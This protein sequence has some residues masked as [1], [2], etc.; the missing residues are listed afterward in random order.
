VSFKEV[1][2]LQGFVAGTLVH[3]DKGLVPIEQLKVGDIV[4]SKHESGQG[5]QAYKR[6]VKT[7]KSAEK[8]K[9]VH[10]KFYDKHNHGDM[11]LFCTEDHSFWVDEMGGWTPLNNLPRFEEVVGLTLRDIHHQGITVRNTPWI[12]L[13]KTSIENI[14]LCSEVDQ[15]E[16][17]CGASMLIDFRNR[18]I[19]LVGSRSG[20]IS[21]YSDYYNWSPLETIKRLPS[22][23]E[24]DEVRFYSKA[25]L[26]SLERIEEYLDNAYITYVYNI[27]VEDFHTYYVGRA[28]VWVYSQP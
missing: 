19:V 26:S 10:I 1:S 7:F 17:S 13:R 16:A 9:I 24:N 27:A 4:L 18:E 21:E 28:G 22:Y 20:L 11:C 15:W 2:N 6:V 12:P 23:D 8:K 25:I 14:A 5:E 3:T